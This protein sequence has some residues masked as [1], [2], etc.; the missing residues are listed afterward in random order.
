[1]AKG[2]IACFEQFLRLP[3]W[4]QKSS[5]S[6]CVRKRLQVG[7]EASVYCHQIR[8]RSACAFVHPH[9][10]LHCSFCCHLWKVIF[11]Q[12]K[13]KVSGND[14]VKLVTNCLSMMQFKGD[15]SALIVSVRVERFTICAFICWND[16]N[17]Q[18][19]YVSFFKSSLSKQVS[20]FPADMNVYIHCTSIMSIWRQ[21]RSKISIE[22]LYKLWY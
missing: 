7:N 22:T 2:D 6:F 18:C 11:T 14:V 10:G 16:L 17:L 12:N 15:N 13:K 3:Q 5:A 1:M 8:F 4:F 21:N 19:Y 20:C 9:Q